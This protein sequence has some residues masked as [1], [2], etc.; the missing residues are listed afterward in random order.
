MTDHSGAVASYPTAETTDEFA[1]NL[2]DVR[3]RM[4]AAAQRAGRAPE[5]VR[6]LPVSKTVPEERIRHAIDAGATFLGEN[7]VQEALR[8]SENLADIPDLE[9]AVIGHLQTNKAKF[10]ARFAAEFHA[11]DSIRLAEA[12]QRRLDI[13]DRT[14]DVFVQVNTSGEESKFGIE[15]NAAEAFVRELP[16]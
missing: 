10:V 2:R 4:D 5:S 3:E 7:K 15:P 8:K 16:A 11:L 1:A 9:W 6:L 12:L 13:E 14:L